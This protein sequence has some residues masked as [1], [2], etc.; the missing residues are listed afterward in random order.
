[1]ALFQ[2]SAMQ[3][4]CLLSS[5]K[6]IN[7][8]LTVIIITPAILFSM[9]A[10]AQSAPSAQEK[11]ASSAAAS[12]ANQ[13]ASPSAA[14]N[15]A[16]ANVSSAALVP[17]FK[18]DWSTPSLKGTVLGPPAIIEG[19]VDSSNP[20]FTRQMTRVQ[21]RPGDP[22]DLYIMK[23]VGV[24]KPPV[25]IYL[26]SYPYLNSQF[27]DSNFA[28]SMTRNGVA[29]IG[30]STALTDQRYHS[31]RAMKE[32]FVSQLPEALATSAHDVQMLIDYLGTRGDMDMDHVGLWGDGSGATIAILA[33]AVDPR[34][35]SLDLVDP[36]G[37]WPDWMAK[38]TII[39][40][41]ERAG[42]NQP[43]FLKTTA[44]LD[45]LQWLPRLK[46]QKIRLQD[47]GSVTVTPKEAREKI[48]AVAPA[49][50]QIVRYADRKAFAESASGGRGFD[51]IK[52]QLRTRAG[53]QYSATG[54]SHCAS[55]GR[56]VNNNQ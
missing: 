25:V 49:N 18:E 3:K 52:E 23:P 24:K 20:T 39:P 5:R 29:A 7:Q 19:D 55:A 46:T 26:F 9:A 48:E 16:H 37:D 28:K 30:F 40:E 4:L 45:P 43:E 47:V 42:L 12:S 54:D 10:V 36:W 27:L 51:W 53:A 31:P 17:A 21:W 1:M 14:S 15:S 11:P 56:E 50:V 38:S 32:W 2:G 34:V 22:I 33:A 6:V 35:K 44:P 8:I 41:N 13:P